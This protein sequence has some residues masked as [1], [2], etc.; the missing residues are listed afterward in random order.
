[1]STIE[2]DRETRAKELGR[3]FAT[4]EQARQML[5]IGVT[6]KTTEETLANL[7]LPPTA[8]RATWASWY[9]ELTEAI[10]RRRGAAPQVVKSSR[11]GSQDSCENDTWETR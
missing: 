9:V 6:Y 4:P 11:C 7:G 2:G 3:T 8:V 5:K 10:S 1:M